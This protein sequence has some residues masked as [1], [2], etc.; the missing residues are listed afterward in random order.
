MWYSV[1]T[2]NVKSD[3]Q[4][5]DTRQSINHPFNN[6][7]LTVTYNRCS[8]IGTWAMQPSNTKHVDQV[9]LDTT[10][11]S[12][13]HTVSQKHTP[14]WS[15]TVLSIGNANSPAM[16]PAP[17]QQIPPTGWNHSARALHGATAWLLS[18]STASHAGLQRPT[19]ATCHRQLSLSAVSCRCHCHWHCRCSAPPPLAATRAHHQAP[20][21]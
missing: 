19:C 9:L 7:T 8:T 21:A 12:H 20:T 10:C 6:G 5:S 4:I 3:E 1:T 11:H 14:T 18:V 16:Q 17:S 15:N 13:Y 2:A